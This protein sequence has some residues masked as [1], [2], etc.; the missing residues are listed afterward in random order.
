MLTL[1]A[2]PDMSNLYIHEGGCLCGA[3]R[4]HT[5]DKAVAVMVCHCAACKQRTGAAYGLGVYFN[6][7]DIEFTKGSKQLFQFVSDESGRWLRT[8]FCG[9]CGTTVSCVVEKRPGMRGIAG[10]S[11]DDLNWFTVESHIWTRSARS[12]M[13]YPDHAKLYEQGTP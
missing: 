10:G 2:F 5:T 12:D 7:D 1:K 13:C 8:E 3:I 6:D 11:Y 9:R 4:F